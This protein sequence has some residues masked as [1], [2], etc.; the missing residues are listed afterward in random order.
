MKMCQIKLI[1]VPNTNKTFVKTAKDLYNFDKVAKFCT[2][3][4]TLVVWKSQTG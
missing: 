1:I 3:L 4:V 2:N